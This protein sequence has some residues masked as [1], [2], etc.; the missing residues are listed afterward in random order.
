MAPLIM[1]P[2]YIAILVLMASF[3]DNTQRFTGR[4]E[5]YDRYRQR[6]PAE[7][8]LAHLRAWCGLT[9]ECVVADIG[10]GTGMLTEV[11]LANGNRTLAVEPNPDMREHMRAQLIDPQLE[12]VDATAEATT[13][14]DGSIDLVA[15]GRAFHWF[16]KDRALA[17]FRRILRPGGWIALVSL[18]RA[19]SSEDATFRAL[20]ARFERLLTE[21]GTDYAYVRNGYRIHDDMRAVFGPGA[22]FHQAQL[23]GTQQ[24]DWPALLGQTM[25]LS[26]VPQ[27]GHPNYDAFVSGLREIF[28]AYAAEGIITLPTMCHITAARLAGL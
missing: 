22:E 9:P 17:E 10:A 15:A 6:Y 24:L 14:R 28:E 25:S 1:A 26:V 5:V 27:P 12:I 16:D 23:P 13:L 2:Q 20:A 7:E 19:H 18:G 8:V 11:F 3:H 4:A 21:H